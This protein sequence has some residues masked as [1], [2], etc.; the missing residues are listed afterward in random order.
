MLCE[1]LLFWI[2]ALAGLIF[3]IFE[4]GI[5]RW[6]FTN[7]NGLA[8]EAANPVTETWG[9]E[10]RFDLILLDDH[11]HLPSNVTWIPLDLQPQPDSRIEYFS[12]IF[13][14]VITTFSQLRFIMSNT[15][16][17]A[18]FVMILIA[19]LGATIY[20]LHLKKEAEKGYL[21]SLVRF[22]NYETVNVFWELNS[23]SDRLRWF[24][25]TQEDQIFESMVVLM[26]EQ[27]NSSRMKTELISKVEKIQ[28]L[29]S[30]LGALVIE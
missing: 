22:R 27:E 6:E 7:W 12:W 3:T 25:S 29:E 28:D 19:F 2:P 26:F 9:S 20:R 17:I 11:L 8:K 21:T 5:P 24:I 14:K 13:T 30:E 10:Q 23:V 4:K 18:T 15:L 16:V 1:R